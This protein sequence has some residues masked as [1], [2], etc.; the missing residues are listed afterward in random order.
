MTVAA[1]RRTPIATTLPSP[2]ATNA[3]FSAA[4]GET[5]PASIRRTTRFAARRP[6]PGPARARLYHDG[7]QCDCGCGFLDPDC[8]SLDAGACDSC[9]V[10]GSCSVQP[11]PGIITPTLNIG[12][13]RPPPPPPS[14]PAAATLM[15]TVPTAIAAVVRSTSTVA[16]IS[17]PAVRSATRAAATPARTGSI[18]P[19][20]RSA[21]RRR[22]AGPAERRRTT[23]S[24]A[25]A[26]A[27]SQTRPAGRGAALR[28][29]GLPR[30]RLLRRRARAHRSRSQRALLR[31]Y[32]DHLD[33]QPRLLR[34]RPL[35]LRLRRQDPD[36]AS[37]AIG[38]CAKCDD[39]GSC[40]TA[41]CPG[42]ITTS[43]NAHCN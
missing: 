2:P 12:C 32:P 27:A 40:S 8:A 5:A 38:V 35:R 24:I 9:N 43:D 33:L 42:S 31:H 30:G 15:G 14:G 25:I 22:A 28:L 1:A 29:P 26:A 23:T 18:P 39:D 37:S 21:C 7:V 11:C 34:R 19:T 17:P 13:S 20:R 3:I 6:L 4:Q 36:C 41:A 10:P 16:P